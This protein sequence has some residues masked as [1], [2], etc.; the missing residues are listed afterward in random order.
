MI[1]K[2]RILLDTEED[3]F[4]DIEMPSESTFEDFHYILLQSFGWQP[5]EMASF[6]ES[7]DN[8][9][10][11][12]EI[13]LMDVQEE[14]GPDKLSVMGD[15][16][17]EEKLNQQGQ[18]MLYVFDFLLMWCF[19]VEV[20]EIKEPTPGEEYP[21][22]VM[23]VGDSPHQMDKEPVD[24]AGNENEDDDDDGYDDSPNYE[25]YSDMDFD[26]YSPN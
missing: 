21:L 8:W 26:Q 12:V 25:D 1:Y 23:Q 16:K 7:N 4:R 2:L 9:D 18:K 24:F 13:P 5:N 20:I 10:K 15:V 11:G 6:Y 3:V 17:L 19:Y 22:L 14:F